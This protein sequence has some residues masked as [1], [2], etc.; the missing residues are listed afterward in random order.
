VSIKNFIKPYA[1]GGASFCKK[2]KRKRQANYIAPL[3]LIS[4]LHSC[5]G[6]VQRE[7]VV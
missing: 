6:E 3:N 2:I 5:P 4:L 7:L 1:P